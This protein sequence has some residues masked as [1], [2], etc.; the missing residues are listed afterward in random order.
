MFSY[1][2]EIDARYGSDAFER[3][4]SANGGAVIPGFVDGHTHTL[5]SGDRVHEFAMKVWEGTRSAALWLT[6]KVLI[7]WARSPTHPL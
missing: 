3:V 2:D 6:P 1:D 7:K 4:I 5:W